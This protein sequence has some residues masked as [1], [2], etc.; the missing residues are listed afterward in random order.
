MEEFL[1]IIIECLF[2]LQN[3]SKCSQRSFINC[4]K[5]F[6]VWLCFFFPS[7]IHTH[8]LSLQFVR[9]EDLKI[10]LSSSKSICQGISSDFPLKRMEEMSA[11]CGTPVC[12]LI[13]H[14]LRIFYYQDDSNMALF[15]KE[16]ILIP[17]KPH[18][19]VNS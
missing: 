9:K 14:F 10:S 15:P 6:C 19:V 8:T 11:A 7:K 17:N 2:R 13:L 4:K 1:I 5:H 12:I 18:P 3:L 16:F